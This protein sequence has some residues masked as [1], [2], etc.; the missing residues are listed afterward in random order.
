MVS[1][2]QNFF[3]I[4]VKY[5][6]EISIV[7]VESC[8]ELYS[9]EISISIKISFGKIFTSFFKNCFEV[10]SV[11]FNTFHL[12][13]N[14]LSREFI[15]F[16]FFSKLILVDVHNL[17]KPVWKIWIWKLFKNLLLI[18]GREYFSYALI[19]SSELIKFVALTIIRPKNVN[20]AER[21]FGQIICLFTPYPDFILVAFVDYGSGDNAVNRI[22]FSTDDVLNVLK[23]TITIFWES[24]KNSSYEE[25]H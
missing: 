19:N 14:K 2:K 11:I 1:H 17:V 15:D 6:L 20:K 22:R 8:I 18:L 21:L 5:S 25:K 7:V 23:S 4:G 3:I 13:P 24:C 10:V 12:I 16:I 9:R